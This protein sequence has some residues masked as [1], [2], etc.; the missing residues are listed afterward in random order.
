MNLTSTEGKISD[1]NIVGTGFTVNK[2]WVIAVD[3]KLR[4]NNVKYYRNVFQLTVKDPKTKMSLLSKTARLRASSTMVSSAYN[5]Q[6][7]FKY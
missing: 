6:E 7:F 1:G 3:L 4:R 5:S 2:N